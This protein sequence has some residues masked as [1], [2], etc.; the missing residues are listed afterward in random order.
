MELYADII[1]DISHADLDKT[2]QYIVPEEFIN[3]INIGSRVKVPFGSLK[4]GRFGYVV[5]LSHKPKIEPERIKKIIDCPAKQLPVES[6]LIKLAG[7]MKDYYGGTMIAALNTVT[8]VKEKVRKTAVRKDTR[9]YIADMVPVEALNEEQQRAISIFKEDYDKGLR[10]TYLIKGVTGSGKTEVYIKAAKHVIEQ[11]KQVIVLVPEIALTYQTVARFATVFHER[12]AIINSSLS[13][14]EKYREFQKVVN[15]DVDVII[16]PR[17]ALFAPFDNLGLIIIDEEHDGAYK[18]ETT[19]KYH[20]RTTAIERA[21][22]DNAAVILGSATPS[23]ESYFKAKAGEYKL[24]NLYKRAKGQEMPEVEVVDLREE[25]NRGNRTMISEKLYNAMDEAFKKG[26][27]AM[28]FLNRRGYRSYVSCRKCGHVM[29]CPRCD[30]SLSLHKEYGRSYLMCHYCGHKEAEPNS[31]PA[32]GS[33]LIGGFGTGT[34]KLEEAVKKVFP[35][36]RTLRM[37]KDTTKR[38]GAHGEIIEAFNQGKADCLIGTQMIV[39]GHDFKKVTVVGAVLADLGLFDNDYTS[40]EKTFDLLCQ[41]AGRAG[42]DKDKGKVIIQT[43]QPDHYAIVTAAA[44]DYENF[45]EYEMAYRRLLR[46][47]PATCLTQILLMSKDEERLEKVSEDMAFLIRDLCKDVTDNADGMKQENA[48]NLITEEETDKEKPQQSKN[49]FSVIGPSDPGI[50]KI[51]D[52]YRKT[53]YI[54]AD[55]K[56]SIEKILCNG[57][58][59][60]MIES[61]KDEVIIEVDYNPSSV[62]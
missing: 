34:E 33:K 53:I 48:D 51:N 8:P 30:V 52:I 15:G 25:L 3:D 24:I 47:P 41:A 29:K 1:I 38:K 60:E 37:D 27:Q 57:K 55:T 22:L 36:I 32:C 50:A 17:S 35:G 20:A 21:R 49:K 16:G 10:D 9:E 28:I 7:W 11:G 39:K 2:F 23:V 31:C 12:I 45:F 58:I 19:P 56:K 13:K 4:N 59:E 42:R 6:R 54:K 44:Q 61:N 18:S 43:Y 26:Q 62:I 40:S 46:F 5:G 14:G